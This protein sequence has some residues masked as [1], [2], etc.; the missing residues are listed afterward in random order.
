MQNISA[1]PRFLLLQ[2]IDPHYHQQEALRNMTE[3]NSLV[4]TLWKVAAQ[5]VQHRVKPDRAT[6][7]GSG[8]VEWLKEKV[9]EKD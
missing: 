1:Q 7:V 4:A 5:A 6:Y 2:V 3:L 9:K 8:K